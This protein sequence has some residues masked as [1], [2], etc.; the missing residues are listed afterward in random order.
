MRRL[1]RE[2][3]LGDSAAEKK[4][5]AARKR[6]GMGPVGPE[7]LEAE[8]R[9]WWKK[10]EKK[11]GDLSYGV[12]FWSQPEWQA[13]GERWG[14]ESPLV[15]TSE[16]GF[17]RILE[18]PEHRDDFKLIEDWKKFLA[19]LGWYYE[20]LTVWAFAF[21]PLDPVPVRVPP[22]TNPRSHVPFLCTTCRRE[23][24]KPWPKG[25]LPLMWDMHPP[26]SAMHGRMLGQCLECYQEKET[27]VARKKRK[28]KGAKRRAVKKSKKRGGKKRAVKKNKKR[29]RARRND[30]LSGGG[31]GGGGGVAPPSSAWAF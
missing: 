16:G 11:W 29:R 5:K 14:N 6:S 4:L 7:R 22:A 25:A 20:S 24:P 31:G 12:R 1:E 2:A 3:A 19:K 17:N 9:A 23:W 21:Y 30:P 15:M 26:P 8:I 18:Y 10:K 27:G 13:R 28:K